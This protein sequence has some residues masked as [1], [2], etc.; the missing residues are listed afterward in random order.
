MQRIGD[1]ASYP[2]QEHGGARLA[3][4]IDGVAGTARGAMRSSC[5]PSP[6]S[7]METMAGTTAGRFCPEPCQA[8][9]FCPAVW[10][11]VRLPGE[12]SSISARMACKSSL[13]EITGNR[14]TSA[15]PRT[16]T[17]T[18]GDA[19]RVLVRPSWVRSSPP[20][21][22]LRWRHSRQA[23]TSS[24]NQQ[25]LRKSSIRNGEGFSEDTPRPQSGA[26][27]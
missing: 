19:V 6:V 7:L 20:H 5:Q 17:K 27:A 13:A 2:R 21:E 15:Q 22:R 24:D 12:N 25:R 18:S 16:Q 14:R 4:R 23:G 9:A 3:R 1:G 26:T 8:Q 10:Q 11:T